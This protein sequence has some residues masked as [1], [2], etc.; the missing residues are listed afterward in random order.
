M[1]SFTV[2]EINI[3]EGSRPFFFIQKYNDIRYSKYIPFFR[4][5]PCFV[6]DTDHSECARRSHK[7]IPRLRSGCSKFIVVNTP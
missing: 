6:E 5:I 1:F 7:V 3:M 2:A 4:V